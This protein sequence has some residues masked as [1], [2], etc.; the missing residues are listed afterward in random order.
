MRADKSVNTAIDNGQIIAR[1]LE[2]HICRRT[3]DL[4]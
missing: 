4:V 2:L 1:N 3:D